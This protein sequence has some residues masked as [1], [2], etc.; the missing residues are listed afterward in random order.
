MPNWH[1]EVWYPESIFCC[2]PV[3]V[4]LFRI[5]WGTNLVVCSLDH[6]SPMQQYDV[7]R[8]DPFSLPC[9]SCRLRYGEDSMRMLCSTACH[10][11]K[12]EDPR[13]ESWEILLQVWTTTNSQFCDEASTMQRAMSRRNTRMSELWRCC[14]RNGL[15]TDVNE[16]PDRGLSST[17]KG[18]HAVFQN[19]IGRLLRWS[20]CYV[21]GDRVKVLIQ[22]VVL[23]KQCSRN[24]ARCDQIDFSL[25]MRNYVKPRILSMDSPTTSI[26]ALTAR[27]ERADQ[28]LSTNS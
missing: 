28:S 27:S 1:S 3:N 16:I 12:A 13:L 7:G 5:L 26:I 14:S 17:T 8:E 19:D 2:S 15:N 18:L 20:R 9:L 23:S 4:H 6:I 25:H 21:S 22:I 24:S 10:H 11:L